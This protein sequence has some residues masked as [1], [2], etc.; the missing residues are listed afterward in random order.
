M[1]ADSEE[2]FFYHTFTHQCLLI[3]CACAVLYLSCEDFD[4]MDVFVQ[5]RK[6]DKAGNLLQNINIPTVDRKKCNMPDP[7]DPINPLI[8]LGPSGCL[9]ASHHALDTE[10]SKP[11]W[12]EPDCTKSSKVP[13]GEI[14]RLEIGLWQTGIAFEAGEQ[15]VLKVSG[16]NM[17]LAEFP[18]LRGGMP[19]FNVGVHKLHIGGEFASHL[20]MPIVNV[21]E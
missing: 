6:A 15:L 8:Y 17:T 9:R 4:D 1:D 10:L 14:V 12:P 7:V 20:V 18:P 2:V 16:H 19:N 5:L 3:G 13:R 11:W 21:A